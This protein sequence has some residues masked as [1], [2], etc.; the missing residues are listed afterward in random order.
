VLALCSAVTC[1]KR[2]WRELAVFTLLTLLAP[3]LTG[4]LTSMTRYAGVAP[5]VYM[6]LALW[7]EKHPRF[8]PIWMAVSAMSLALLATLFA[9]GINVGGA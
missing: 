3:L 1:W 6:A 7:S 2:G 9:L 8:G 5:G 4:T